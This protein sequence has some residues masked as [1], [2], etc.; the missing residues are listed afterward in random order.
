MD[1]VVFLV[2]KALEGGYIARGSTES[3]FTEADS[4][5][6]LKAEIHDAVAC[7]FGDTEIPQVKLRY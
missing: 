2:E 6:D 5:N 7:H 3:I 4:I 1:H